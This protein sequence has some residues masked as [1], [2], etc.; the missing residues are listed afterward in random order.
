MKCAI[1]GQLF[2]F[3]VDP[4]VVRVENLELAYCP[5]A[6]HEGSVLPNIL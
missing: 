6:S 4:Q 5:P 2:T 1:F 3:E